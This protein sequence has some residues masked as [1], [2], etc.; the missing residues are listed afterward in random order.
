VAGDRIPTRVLGVL[1]ALTALAPLS[2]D[3]Y[4]PSLPDIQAELGGGEWLAQASI[5]ACLLGIGVGQ[6]LWG[7]LS[8]RLG[9]RGVIFGGVAAWTFASV[10]SAFAPTAAILV[11]VRGIA[12]L[13]GAAGI[14][15][16]RS[17]VRDR[18]ARPDEVASG[19]GALAMVTSLAP[20]VAPLLGSVIAAGW[21]WRGDFVVLAIAGALLL[22][23]FGALV[24]ETL[25]SA[26]RTAGG[27]AAVLRSLAAAVRDRELAFVAL[28]LAAQAVGF[29]AYI[30]S[31]SFIVEREFGH[32]P[33]AF[34]LVFG[35]NAFAM[36]AANLL[37]RRLAHRRHPSVLLG[38]GLAVS[39]GAGLALQLLGVAGAPGWA[40]WVA[41][42][43][44]AAS[45]G[46]VLPGAH[47]WGQLT[48]VISGAASASTGAAQF[49]GGVLGS[50]LTGLLGVT[51]ARLGLVIALSSAGA[52]AAWAL[53]RRH[54]TIRS[55]AKETA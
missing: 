15:V 16:A 3:I 39:A 37:F 43:A 52:L 20:V 23:A 30:A 11:A 21:G 38:V 27:G 55:Y 41:G 25:P 2:M 26:A 49:L 28:A 48:L 7:P 31:A 35:S 22:A 47:G 29:Y 34:A 13:G 42:V 24:P 54:L 33:L 18:A 12:G 40:C 6:L 14:V 1:A 44:F 46:F 10:L 17:I 32:P 19:I 50:P 8:D 53:A 4:T 51:A 45:M 5:T 9:R 36:F